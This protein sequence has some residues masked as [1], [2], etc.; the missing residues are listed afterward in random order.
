MMSVDIERYINSGVLEAYVTGAA[1]FAEEQ[2]IMQYRQQ[3]P[4]VNQALQQLEDD[5]ERM[6]YLMAIEPPPTIW[7][8][9]EDDINGIIA[10]EQTL[11]KYFKEQD[12]NNDAKEAK[13]NGPKYI[14][15]EAESNYI[16]VH[17][18]WKWILATIFILGKIFLISAIFFY[19]E[20]RQAQ[21]QI[22]ELKQEIHSLKK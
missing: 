12:Y 4:Q 10:R 3:Y 8:K 14:E 7:D 2:E 17:K 19:L 16:R 20:N 1:S 22:I 9:I 18:S 15:I 11:P 6:A 13:D 21:Q 5:L